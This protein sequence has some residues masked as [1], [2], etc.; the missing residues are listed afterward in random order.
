MPAVNEKVLILLDSFIDI[1]EGMDALYV[2]RRAYPNGIHY[3]D[4]SE[5]ILLHRFFEPQD[6][7]LFWKY[8]AGGDLKHELP[9]DYQQ[10]VCPFDREIHIHRTWNDPDRLLLP[11]TKTVPGTRLTS[12]SIARELVYQQIEQKNKRPSKSGQ[13]PDDRNAPPYWIGK[14]ASAWSTG[15]DSRKTRK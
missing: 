1:V 13:Y 7:S 11:Q 2:A 6:V 10:Y 3:F 15:A 9:E 14:S 8:L 4:V 5:T 12:K